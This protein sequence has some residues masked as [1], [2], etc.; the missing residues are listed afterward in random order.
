MARSP[1]AIL[2]KMMPE[3]I[4]LPVHTDKAYGHTT[5]VDRDGV[6]VA[7]CWMAGHTRSEADCQI[8]AAE[9]EH[10]LNASASHTVLVAALKDLIR[11]N[12]RCSSPSQILSWARDIARTALATT[13]ENRG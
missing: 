9:I 10:A 4:K 8:V 12:H 7:H 3:T 11:G 2:V 1:S 5:V 13:R 6:L